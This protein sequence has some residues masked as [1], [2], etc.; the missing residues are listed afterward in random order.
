MGVFQRP[1]TVL[2]VQGDDVVTPEYLEQ[3][4]LRKLSQDGTP[5]QQMLA[6][7]RLAVLNASDRNAFQGRLEAGASQGNIFTDTMN[8]IGSTGTNLDLGL[9]RIQRTA[10]GAT[11]E[12]F[13][14]TFK[15]L[16]SNLNI[17]DEVFEKPF[18]VAFDRNVERITGVHPSFL[19]ELDDALSEQ[20]AGF[21][22]EL[23]GEVGGLRAFGRFGVE[24]TLAVGE[25]VAAGMVPGGIPSLVAIKSN[26]IGHDVYNESGSISQASVAAGL[27]FIGTMM[28]FKIGGKRI[29]DSM[30]KLDKAFLG[31]K[32]GNI[33]AIKR[34]GLHLSQN[35]AK[36]SVEALAGAL[37][38]IPTAGAIRTAE[39]FANGLFQNWIEPAQRI[40]RFELTFGNSVASLKAGLE[41]GVVFAL[42]PIGT[43]AIGA[44]VSA[45]KVR[46]AKNWVRLGEAS[47][48]GYRATLA[49][50]SRATKGNKVEQEKLLKDMDE[51]KT[52]NPAFIAQREALRAQVKGD[53]KF[54]PS[55]IVT[56]DLTTREAADML[57]E[58]A[59]LVDMVVDVRSEGVDPFKNR[60][61]KD[62]REPTDK[63]HDL[64]DRQ[65]ISSPQERTQ[66]N[67]EDAEKAIADA[68]RDINQLERSEGAVDLLRK[69]REEAGEVTAEANV[70]VSELL[71]L[72][73]TD[74]IDILKK[75]VADLKEG[76]LTPEKDAAIKT[77]QEA[78][79]VFESKARL[80]KEGGIP[81]KTLPTPKL[82]IEIEGEKIDGERAAKLIAKRNLDKLT[83]EEV[84]LREKLIEKVREETGSDETVTPAQLAKNIRARIKERVPSRKKIVKEAGKE[85]GLSAE[86][87]VEA[88]KLR[89]E[90]AR[91][92]EVEKSVRH[93]RTL[94]NSVA[95]NIKKT[96]RATKKN[97]KQRATVFNNF[98]SGIRGNLR[99]QLLEVVKTKENGKP[100]FRTNKELVDAIDAVNKKLDSIV[101]KENNRR[102]NRQL[103]KRTDKNKTKLTPVF[104]NV[105]TAVIEIVRP[106]QAKKLGVKGSN[107]K[108]SLKE[109]AK[110]RAEVYEIT[111]K[112]AREE[113]GIEAVQ[114]I[115]Q[116]VKAEGVENLTPAESSFLAQFTELLEVNSKLGLKAEKEALK[117]EIEEIQDAIFEEMLTT[118]GVP[119]TAIKR[120]A[121]TGRVL[122]QPFPLA[123]QA[124]Q[125]TKDVSLGLR[126][127]GRLPDII[128]FLSGGDRTVAHQVLYRDVVRGY[129]DAN[130]KE[131]ELHALQSRIFE[132]HGLSKEDIEASMDFEV[133]GKKVTTKTIEMP[134]KT[135]NLELTPGEIVGYRTRAADPFTKEKLEDK[136]GGIYRAGTEIG[137]DHSKAEHE[138]VME[139]TRDTTEARVAEALVEFYNTPEVT[140]L[141]REYGL[142]N[143]GVDIIKNNNGTYVPLR[144]RSRDA[145]KKEERELEEKT[146]EDI[147]DAVGGAAGFT[148]GTF[149][150]TNRSIVKE[151][152]G[153]VMDVVISDGLLQ[154]NQFIH[155][156]A[157]LSK[158]EAP[159]KKAEKV[160]RGGELQQFFGTR[161]SNERGM[162][163]D[164]SD[165]FYSELKRSERGVT[166]QLNTPEAFAR[167]IRNN[168]VQANLSFN[169]TIPMYQPLS[170]L[171]A[172]VY[173]G[174]EGV[175]ALAKANKDIF[176]R[177]GENSHG[178]VRERM[179]RI[180][181]LAWRRLSIRNAHTVASG[182]L[183]QSKQKTVTIGNETHGR[184]SL[185]MS[186][187]TG[188]DHLAITT[189]FRMSEIIISARFK[190]K[191]IDVAKNSKLYEEAVRREFEDAIMETQPTFD[192]IMQSGFMIRGIS[193]DPAIR[194]TLISFNTMF[195]GY[196]SKLASIQ[197]RGLMRAI[198]DFKRGNIIGGSGHLVKAA[199]MTVPGSILVPIIRNSVKASIVTGFLL[200]V[201]KEE[202]VGEEAISL[203]EKTAYDTIGQI[204]GVTV[205]G[206]F[207][208]DI[209]INLATGQARSPE[210]SPFTSTLSQLTRSMYSTF[211]VN[212][213]RRTAMENTRTVIS[214]MR[215]TQ[216][217]FG[218]PTYLNTLVNQAIREADEEDVRRRKAAFKVIR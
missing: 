15:T 217:V 8:L 179:L 206:D 49:V 86:E 189:I 134:G 19:G 3:L 185:G 203:A 68:E 66:K 43:R 195:R 39:Q 126:F 96:A 87:L 41:E 169:L 196:T 135:P 121:K 188:M 207:V 33:E 192:P 144:Q 197:S 58:Y 40:E 85:E 190:T 22:N 69:A 211:T 139:Q 42:L 103:R 10:L 113:L 212:P 17:P 13:K 37:T 107:L 57:E 59:G 81:D 124:L 110:D 84:A 89:E 56:K 55:E 11:R 88:Q 133:K 2:D 44:G 148:R 6:T 5:L 177:S 171:T 118:L 29:K 166:S 36:Q 184:E 216:S 159:L 129:L 204:L 138:A 76:E 119:S 181:G 74:A 141:I 31:V 120:D 186:G 132:K 25:F 117:K 137:R 218:V 178:K 175:G 164:I 215:A 90:N 61:E 50:S 208:G 18:D 154:A 194:S 209:A 210:T 130:L 4:R 98:L 35:R 167:R 122:R 128:E 199:L 146:P 79:K 173:W 27:N 14:S 109:L 99:R 101:T 202:D 112:Q 52:D 127:N 38:I 151:R 70:I 198:R 60:N 104:D 183:V 149:G 67:I 75:E 48:L 123:R 20:S 191:G 214:L 163:D 182:E 125:F 45:G 62:T 26:S 174:V 162:F 131:A 1:Q 94:V 102:I 83:P 165:V 187:I 156:I 116:K 147:L 21:H 176:T 142:R 47:E 205:L 145:S 54:E 82:E 65:R 72:K 77:A 213:N 155:A 71:R 168:I 136:K 95:K 114:E 12:G 170:E 30:K 63:D 80:E 92:L 51:V 78:L 180:S 93:A 32:E 46:E 100:V 152:T 24:T 34:A 97:Q 16:F 160:L 157:T 111:E 73:T 108:D 105:L 172:A 158:L 140:S 91:Q 64:S 153:K 193:S 9:L 106:K 23:S 115:L 161:K 200:A 53:T 201:G 150:L 7:D 143:S 28:L